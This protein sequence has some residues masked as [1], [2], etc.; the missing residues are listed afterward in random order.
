MSDPPAAVQI[1]E[2]LRDAQAA[3][4]AGQHDQAEHLRRLAVFIARDETQRL[5]DPAAF[6]LMP[7]ELWP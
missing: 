3:E 4:R 1:A 7:S 6:V 5:T 2:A